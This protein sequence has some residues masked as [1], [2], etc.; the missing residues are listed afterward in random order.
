MTK[1]KNKYTLNNLIFIILLSLAIVGL[2]FVATAKA[3]ETN[4]FEF[5]PLNLQGDTI[6]LLSRQDFGMGIGWTIATLQEFVEIRAESVFP[7][8]GEGSNSTL[9]GVGVGMNIPKLVEKLGGQWFLSGI[10]SS[11]GVLGLMDFNATSEKDEIEPAIYL[12][13][14]KVKF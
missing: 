13:V 10:T 7:I 1:V 8:V 12:T 14:V 5:N 9:V 4:I 11:I 6:Y 2:L 3:E